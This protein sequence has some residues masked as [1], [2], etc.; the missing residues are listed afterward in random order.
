MHSVPHLW[1]V[2]RILVKILK[3]FQIFIGNTA[4]KP[5]CLSSINQGFTAWRQ[6]GIRQHTGAE[7]RG[8]KHT[9]D[10]VRGQEHTGD[11]IR[12]QAHT[13]DEVRGQEHT[14]DEVRGQEHTGDEV[15][16][17]E[18]TG[19]ESVVHSQTHSR[20]GAELGDTLETE[21]WYLIGTKV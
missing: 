21:L 13:G 6:C 4:V 11:E 18:H 19:D 2:D 14:G 17:Q 20:R 1:N 16:G 5:R 12:A 9:G 7:V 8:Q 10:E 3:W 15:S